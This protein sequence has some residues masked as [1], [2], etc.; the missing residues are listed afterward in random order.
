MTDL[1]FYQRFVH[2]GG[3]ACG[4]T[5]LRVTHRLWDRPATA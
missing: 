5:L 2:R 1:D 4:F 3:L